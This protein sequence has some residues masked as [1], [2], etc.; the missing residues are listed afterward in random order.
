MK[1]N[2]WTLFAAL[3][4]AILAAITQVTAAPA[5]LDGNVFV[6]DA[7]RKGRAADEKGDVITFRDGTFH[8]SMCDQWGYGKGNYQAVAEGDGV[9][10]ETETVSEKDGRL[11]W[12]GMVKGDTIEGVFTHYRKPKWYRKNPAPIEHWFKGKLKQP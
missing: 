5:L 4:V 10:F 7:G 3:M 6:A 9:R 11:T 8:S 12:K 2:L 1:P